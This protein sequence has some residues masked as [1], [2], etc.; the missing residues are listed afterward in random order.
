[1]PVF[2]KDNRMPVFCGDSSIEEDEW[3]SLLNLMYWDCL[4][5]LGIKNIR[6]LTSTFRFLK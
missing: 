5:S 3:I 2:F 6:I 4:W 1:M